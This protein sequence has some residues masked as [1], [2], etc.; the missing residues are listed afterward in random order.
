MNDETDVRYCE[1]CGC[2]IL[3]DEDVGFESAEETERM[4][5][6]GI[7]KAGYETYVRPFVVCRACA[8]EHMRE[9]VGFR[10]TPEGQHEC[11]PVRHNL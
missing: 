1:E 11:S 10:K 4:C 2:E 6:A 9:W 5:L 3:S 7:P 8:E